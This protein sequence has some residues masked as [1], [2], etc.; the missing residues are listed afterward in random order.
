MDIDKSGRKAAVGREY[1]SKLV[2]ELGVRGRKSASKNLGLRCPRHLA[3]HDGTYATWR[4]LPLAWRNIA[5]TAEC[6]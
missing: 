2:D 6:L 1:A 4:T 5:S 3:A